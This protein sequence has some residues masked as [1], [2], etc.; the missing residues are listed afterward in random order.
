MLP[1]HCGSFLAFFFKREGVGTQT[2]RTLMHKCL[3]PRTWAEVLPG[4]ENEKKAPDSPLALDKGRVTSCNL[5]F[6][7]K[8]RESGMER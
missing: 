1:C 4:Q 5:T 7:K 3:S 2:N 6:L 8:I